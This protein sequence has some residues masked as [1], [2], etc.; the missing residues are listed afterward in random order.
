MLDGK[1]DQR[2][3][4]VA[5]S[6]RGMSFGRPTCGAKINIIGSVEM[7]SMLDPVDF[8]LVLNREHYVT[9]VVSH[10]LYPKLKAK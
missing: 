8:F 9:K 3:G 5:L 7:D 2:G 1:E 6:N 10:S 4:G